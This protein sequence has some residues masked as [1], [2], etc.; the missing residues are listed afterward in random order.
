MGNCHLVGV[1][2]QFEEM[3]KALEMYGDNSCTVA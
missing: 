2:F 3:K 1:E